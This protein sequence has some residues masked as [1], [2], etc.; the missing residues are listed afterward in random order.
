MS[1]PK[2]AHPVELG[3]IPSSI[4]ISL[5]PRVCVTFLVT[6][7]GHAS[8]TAGSTYA[9][10]LPG[11]WRTVETNRDVD[12]SAVANVVAVRRN[13]IVAVLDNCAVVEEKKRARKS[14]G[15]AASHHF[16]ALLRES[17]CGVVVLFGADLVIVGS[18]EAS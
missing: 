3:G 10:T 16:R 14:T 18:Q 11:A 4:R 2:T 17:G 1:G 15:T 7:P 13:H 9:P 8:S 12:E 5:P 6:Y